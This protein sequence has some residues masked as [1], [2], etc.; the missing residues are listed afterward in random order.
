MGA[1]STLEL[2]EARVLMT[3]LMIITK[4]QTQGS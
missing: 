1:Y 2:T 4:Y 3:I